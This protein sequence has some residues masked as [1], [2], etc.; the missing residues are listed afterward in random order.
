MKLAEAVAKRTKDLLFLQNK[1]QYRLGKDTCLSR[2][3]I[4]RMFHG[5]TSNVSLSTICLFAQF[6][7]MTLK[8]FFDDPVFDPENLEF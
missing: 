7:N 6:F 3:A 4:Q 1:T 8:E 5:K 2:T